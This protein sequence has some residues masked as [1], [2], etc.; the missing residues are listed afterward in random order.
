MGIISISCKPTGDLFLGISKD[1]RAEF[2]SNRFKLS[3]KRHANKQLQELWDRYGEN[4][5]EYS[6]VEV[7]QYENLEDDPTDNLLHRYLQ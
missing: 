7:L 6:V 4:D 5:F 3:I 1:T 2:N